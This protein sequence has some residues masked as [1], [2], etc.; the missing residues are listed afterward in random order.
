MAKNWLER[1]ELLIGENKVEA[2]SKSNVLIVGLGGVG[3]FAAEFLCRAGIGSFTLVDGD[4]YDLTNKNRQIMATAETIGLSKAEVTAKRL[5]SINPNVKLQVLQLFVKPENIAALL[6]EPYDFVLDCIDSITPKIA[7]IEE[8]KKR[9]F[10]VISSMGAGGRLNPNLVEVADLRKTRACKLAK[11]IRKRLQ[12]DILKMGVPVVYSSE[13][14][15]ESSLQLT[16]GSNFKKS[17]YGTISYM[18]AIFGLY[19]AWYVLDM[20]TKHEKTNN[21]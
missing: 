4:V 15:I 16:D 8:A 13:L 3:G 18:P 11:T 6:S 2:L 14:V 19:M 7:L 10:A 17:F 1:T 20:L 5:Q 21:I 9:N 12:K